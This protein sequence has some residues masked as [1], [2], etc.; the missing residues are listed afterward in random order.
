MNILPVINRL[1]STLKEIINVVKPLH[2]VGTLAENIKPFDKTG[3]NPKDVI[4]LNHRDMDGFVSGIVVHQYIG[5][6]EMIDVQYNE[7]VDLDKLKIKDTASRVIWIDHHSSAIKDMETARA[8]NSACIFEGLQCSGPAGCELS[9]MF[10]HGNMYNI[11]PVVLAVGAYDT[12][13]FNND[14]PN[15]IVKRDEQ[16]HQEYIYP[17]FLALDTKY[18]NQNSVALQML[19]DPK[20]QE[21]N[22]FFKDYRP[23]DGALFELEMCLPAG[24]AI[25]DYIA[26]KASE[27][28]K[29]HAFKVVIN[30]IKFVAMFNNRRGSGEFGNAVEATECDAML[31][32]LPTADGV[33]LSFYSNNGTDVSGVAKSLGGGGHRG[34]AG[35]NI[36]YDRLMEIISTR[37]PLRWK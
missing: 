26:K 16:F 28:V 7:P 25:A 4:I 22:E 11:S 12:F 36:T 32:I 34:A 3:I 8:N 20:F 15:S 29:Y 24:R 21:K 5:G 2:G 23:N 33:S 17:L 18:I 13:R 37:T 30:D 31:A 35:C 6:G 1:H 10:M 14:A 19:L 9:W 27:A